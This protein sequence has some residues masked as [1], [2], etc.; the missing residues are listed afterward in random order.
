MNI[1]AEIQILQLVVLLFGSDSAG[2]AQ[3]LVKI[4]QA[5]ARAYYDHVGQ[6]IDPSLIKPEAGI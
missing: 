6:P 1:N 4:V 3:T 2:V 5:A